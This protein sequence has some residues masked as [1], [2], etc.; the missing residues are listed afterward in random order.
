MRRA[1]LL[2]AVILAA[3][4]SQPAAP[5][6]NVTPAGGATPTAASSPTVAPTQTPTPTENISGN[7]NPNPPPAPSATPVPP[8]ISVSSYGLLISGGSLQV[9]DACAKVKA[10]AP[11]APSSVQTCSPGLAAQL[12]P[13]VSATSDRIYYRDGDTKVRYM[14]PSGQTGDATTVPGS[15]TT[16]S[17]FSVTP[18]DSRIAVLVEDLSQ[19]LTIS[20]R[21]YEEDVVGGGG[22][23][24]L[25]AKTISK[26]Q[27]YTLWP[28]GWHGG[29]LVLALLTACSN[30][31]N[32][33]SPAEWHV[34]EPATDARKVTITNL[35][36]SGQSGILSRWPSPGGVACSDFN[37]HT[38]FID[39]SGAATGP[40]GGSENS[41]DMLSGVSP[42][43][44]RFFFAS[45]TGQECGPPPSSCMESTSL[46]QGMG[47]IA[48][49]STDPPCLWIDESYL[50]T[51]GSVLQMPP[52]PSNV[53]PAPATR[54]DM[55][56]KGTCAGRFP[57]GL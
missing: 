42:S 49:A 15:S 57:G 23:V 17:F 30:N 53:T 18:D 54:V 21:L 19:P 26:D 37:W 14:T 25:D 4:C 3:A 29:L 45:A 28:M 9:I 50:L 16:V 41:N 33:L 51:P 52:L 27:G 1:L 11:I 32:S 24:E 34:F 22:H 40:V 20:L 46:G 31:P 43:G 38:S 8:C 39:W 47:V 44:K 7:P 48:T 12:E 6:A 36:A 2:G 35:C 56:A 10:S 5:V 55:A 13:P